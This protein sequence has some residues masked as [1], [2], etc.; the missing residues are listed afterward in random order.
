[1]VSDLIIFIKSIKDEDLPVSLKIESSMLDLGSIMGF[2]FDS[3]VEFEFT[4]SVFSNV[5]L[6]KGDIRTKCN[7]ECNRC[8][9]KLELPVY[10]QNLILNYENTGQDSIDLSENI[11]EEIILSL[12]GKVLCMDECKGFCP[13]CKVNLNEETCF[14]DQSARKNTFNHI[15]F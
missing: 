7:A 13:G 1:M 15:C 12:P 3:L 6:V 14:C 4:V 2:E 9:K 8:L 10:C 5:I 11:R